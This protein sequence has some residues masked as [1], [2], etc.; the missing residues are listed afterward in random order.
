MA[1][2]QKYTR[3]ESEIERYR[4]E[5]NWA[6][7]VE[8]AQFLATK[9][10]GLALFV[11]LIL[12]ESKLEEYL[13]ENE[14]IESNITK[15]KTQLGEGETYLQFVT[16]QDNKHYVE[17]SL[18]QAK[19]HYC[20]GL[21]Q[22]AIDVYNR[23]KLDEIKESQVTSS[24]LLCILAE[25]HAIKGLCLEKI[26]PS[27]TSKFKQVDLED[28]IIECFEK[29][30][31]LALSYLQ[32]VDNSSTDIELG[33]ILETAIQQSPLLHMKR[34]DISKGVA[35]LRDLL[36]T[37][38]S[39]FTQGLRLTLARQ[40]AEVLLRGIN[41]KKYVP[42]GIEEIA[43]TKHQKYRKYS[44]EKLFVPENEN[45][46]SL[47]LLLIAE[48]IATREAVLNRTEE[49]HDARLHSLQNATAVYDLLAIALVKRAQFNKL[50][51]S[52][53]R[54]M[55]FSFEEFHI[56]HQFAN[57]L[58]C[59]RKYNRA[60]LVL[61]ECLRL[62]PNNCVVL[63]QVAKLCY[64]YLYQYDTG[65]EL[66]EKAVEENT[67]HSL[68]ARM[69]VALGVGYSLKALEMKLQGE[70]QTLHKK[71]LEAFV[72][73]HTLDPNDYLAL[74]HLALQL[75][76]HRQIN[77]AMKYVRLALR[78]HSDHIHSLHLMVLLLS[79]Q[80]QY[81]EAIC[82]MRAALDEYPNN[83]SLMLTKSKLEE[84]VYGPNQALD[85]C[86]HMLKLWKDLYET[87]TSDS[88]TESRSRNLTATDRSVFDKKS[89]AQLQLTE[90][91]DRD[92]GSMKAESVAASRVERTLS[93]VASSYNSNFQPRPG[94]QQT[95]QIQAQ[96]WLH[97]AELYLSVNKLSEAEG[98]V[99]ETSVIFPLS[100]HV[101]YIKGRLNEH[102][103]K[104]EEARVCYEN[105]LSINPGH[106]KSLQ[107]LGMVLHTLGNDR[108]A[109][110]VLR[111]AVNIDPIAHQSWFNLGL[112]LESLGHAEPASDCH[113][114]A[115]ELE[116]TSPI[117]P[118]TVIP[119]LLH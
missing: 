81:E 47:L 76:I 5:A 33:V 87:D 107:H 54:A 111:D 118:F 103:Q 68:T 78:Y 56:W 53:E 31:D 1:S 57:S 55:R 61:K 106:R 32:D 74:F 37:I 88:T 73:A 104:Y 51:D 108:M 11:N 15:A 60:L 113:L 90:L 48:A 19:I 79:A 82:L 6:K 26:G 18:L 109:E 24:R 112:V 49:Y 84:I 62:Q 69:Y 39:R 8:T 41:E 30:G 67:D 80:K 105:A 66:M 27:T 38:E 17:A 3:L 70:R 115:L 85:T 21:Y 13:L 23:V 36:R 75:A 43:K 42:M 94:S 28:R 46:E 77:D 45:E 114:K 65:I 98:C 59:A 2:K 95:L 50:S 34:G 64:E 96:I 93:E 72:R 7:A 100:Y 14:P 10:Q 97:L 71:A 117:V 116:A 92:T 91:N 44:G 86:K 119:R 102:K 16:Q 83:L 12:G 20:K 99:T 63:L 58:L 25:S 29:A 4:S 35:R 110:K 101:A 52:F 40:L 89:F 22:S 9:N